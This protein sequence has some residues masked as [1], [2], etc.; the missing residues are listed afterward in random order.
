MFAGFQPLALRCGQ[1]LD[2]INE[3]AGIE[4]FIRKMSVNFP[5]ISMD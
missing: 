5:D 3:K 1:V 2:Y 4:R